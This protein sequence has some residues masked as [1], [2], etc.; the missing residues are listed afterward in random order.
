MTKKE[1]PTYTKGE[2]IFNAVTHIVGGAFGIFALIMCVLLAI[3]HN[4]TSLGMFSIVLYTSTIIILYTMS[5]IYH[6]LNRNNAKKVFRIFDHCTIYL[7]IAGTYSPICLISLRNSPWGIIL[8][9]IVWGC[10]IIGIT[11]NA[12]NMYWKAVKIISMILY[13]AMG[14]CVIFAIFPLLEVVPLAC[15][16]WLLAGGLAY[17]LGVIFYGLGKKIKYMHSIWHLF[18]ILGTVLQFIA[19]YVYII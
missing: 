2:E 4:Q 12:I 8:F 3:K 7:L 13:I 1:L 19:I 16:Y 14:W 5:S 10:A 18:C 9:S 15:F 11:F 6:F 17:T